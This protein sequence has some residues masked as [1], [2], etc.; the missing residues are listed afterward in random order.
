MPTEATERRAIYRERK[1]QG[2]CPRCGVKV[3]KSSKFIYCDD[4][5]AYFRGYFNE[6]AEDVNEARRSLYAERKAN[7][8]CPRCGKKLAKRYTLTLCDSCL[9]KQYDYN[10]R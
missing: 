1:E 9:D 5:R 10:N 2:F 4:C 8:Q 7:H 6:V 3:K